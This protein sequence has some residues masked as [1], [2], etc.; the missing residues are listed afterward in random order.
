MAW[1]VKSDGAGGYL[2]TDDGGTLRQVPP[3]PG[4]W[5]H[6]EVLRRAALDPGDPDYVV[7]QPADPPP[8]PPT[9]DE[10]YDA[11]IARDR[12]FR[13]YVLAVND[14]SIVPGANMSGADIKTAIKARM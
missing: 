14:G 1:T 7:I 8:P 12:V 13:A 4:N 11:V 2:V 10:I 3:D 9:A 5:W 6:Q